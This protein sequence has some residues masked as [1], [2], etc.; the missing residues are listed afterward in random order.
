MSLD[1][2]KRGSLH[3]TSLCISPYYYVFKACLLY[4]VIFIVALRCIYIVALL[5]NLDVVDY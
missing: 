3:F 5:N 2:L 4:F 1:V